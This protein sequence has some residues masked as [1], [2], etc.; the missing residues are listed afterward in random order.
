MNVTFKIGTLDLSSKLSTYKVTWEVSYQ[1]II[2]T[3][4]NVEH[5]FSAPKRAIVDFSLL[6][7]DDA[8]AEQTQTVTFTDPYSA[9]DITRS[10]RI[11]NNLEAE[12]GLKSVNGKRYY[13]GGEIQMRA[14]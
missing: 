7:L 8:L 11:T 4:D 6:P 3:L 12:F 2:T 1:K 5:P 14:N 10:M 13:K 9:A